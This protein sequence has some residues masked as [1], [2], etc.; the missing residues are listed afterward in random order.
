MENDYK[1]GQSYDQWKKNYQS[2]QTLNQLMASKV[3]DPTF[4]FKTLE[5]IHIGPGEKYFSRFGH[6][7]MRF[8]GSSREKPENDLT[9]SFM[10]DANDFDFS[11]WAGFFGGKYAIYP[12]IQ[13][14]KQVHDHYKED[15]NRSLSGY[16]IQFNP[17]TKEA[18]IRNL[19]QF[20]QNPKLL[21]TYAMLDNSC[22]NGLNKYLL[23]SGFEIKNIDQKVIFPKDLLELW[24]IQGLITDSPSNY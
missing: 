22:T 8:Q 7:L 18:L 6:V 23:D 21:G 17:K 20:I 4:D 12:L 15:Q 10:I 1:S 5:L 2:E 9:V 16:N 3:L 14:M 19:R 24:K 13:T 11:N